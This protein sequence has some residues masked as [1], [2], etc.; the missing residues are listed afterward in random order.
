[1]T[2]IREPGANGTCG[3]CG[4]K[5]SAP[6]H[7]KRDMPSYHPFEDPAETAPTTNEIVNKRSAALKIVCPACD[8]PPNVYC[9][10]WV[11]DH[12]LPYKPRHIHKV[13]IDTAA[14][15]AL[16]IEIVEAAT[17]KVE[18]RL[19]PYASE[20]LRDRADA[21]LTRQLDHERFYTRFAR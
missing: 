21:G 9:R 13:R 10:K 15:P 1:M 20:H 6:R 17:G 12:W 7:R 4:C 18:R 11:I 3:L 2:T 19:G 14:A 5:K 8:A 16:C